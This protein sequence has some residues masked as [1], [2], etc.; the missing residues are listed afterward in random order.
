MIL[1]DT[2]VWIDHLRNGNAELTVLL[3]QDEVLTHP[4]I[5]GELAC[6]TLRN[7]TEI[8]RLLRELPEARLAEHQEALGLLESRRL[9][10]CGIGWIDVHLLASALLSHSTVWT[11]DKQLSEVASSLK[12]R[13]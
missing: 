9:W 1:V 10:G 2:S 8:L 4:F 6:G 7:R 3:Q 5:I 11:L 13:K 12:L